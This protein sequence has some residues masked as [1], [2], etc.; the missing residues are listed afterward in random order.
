M[1]TSEATGTRTGAAS[2]FPLARRYCVVT[3]GF[4][5]TLIAP[6]LSALT[7]PTSR[8][9]LSF[10]CCRTAWV[11]PRATP[12][13]RAREPYTTVRAG[14]LS[15]RTPTLNQVERNPS[16]RRRSPPAIEVVFF[17]PTTVRVLIRR[18]EF[19][20]GCRSTTR[21]G[22]LSTFASLAPVKGNGPHLWCGE[23]ES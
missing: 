21:P 3:V 5:T 11:R 9:P 16:R 1:R 23:M 15:D 6:V 19:S 13:R 14:G 20:C 2:T 8:H 10:R 7:A 12:L 17:V 18:D 22:I 4:T